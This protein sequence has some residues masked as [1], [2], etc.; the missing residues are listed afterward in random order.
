MAFIRFNIDG[1]IQLSRN[2]RIAAVQLENMRE[3]YSEA[4]D[5]MASRSDD[6]FKKKGANVKK[7]PTWTKLSPKTEK[8]RDRRWGYYKKPPN[9]PSL[10]RWTW[11]LQ[12]SKKKKTNN[13]YWSLEFTAPYAVYH[14][15]WSKNLPKRAIIDLDNPTN[16]EIV[17]ALQKKIN[18]DLKISGLQR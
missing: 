6:I 12:N 9:K 15:R 10:L 8:A 7:N 4:V 2:L 3:F 14:Q 11:K 5:I 17:R 16:A 13:N 18:R 1:D